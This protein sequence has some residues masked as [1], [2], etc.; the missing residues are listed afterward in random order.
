MGYLC[1]GAGWPNG[2]AFNTSARPNQPRPELRRTIADRVGVKD[3]CAWTLMDNF[4]WNDGDS[5]RLGL[6]PAYYQTPQGTPKL[7]ARRY[8]DDIRGNRLV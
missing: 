1:L 2:A 3:Y 5:A 4:E 6:W 8:A 7:S